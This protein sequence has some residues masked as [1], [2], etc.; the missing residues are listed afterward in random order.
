MWPLTIV[1]FTIL[2][3]R[4]LSVSKNIAI[5]TL[6]DWL[7]A[8]LMAYIIPA[9][10]CNFAGLNFDDHIIHKISRNAL[11]PFTILIVMSSMS[12]KELKSIGWKPLVVFISGS[13]FIALFPVL[14]FIIGKF[15]PYI[16]EWLNAGDQWKGLI[17]V[18]G[19]W[20]GGSISQLVLKEA[21]ECPENVFLSILIFD[22]LMVNIWTIIMFQFIKRSDVINNRLGITAKENL[23][24]INITT[25]N[26][27]GGGWIL[28]V[29]ALITAMNYVLN[30]PFITQIIVLSLTGLMIGNFW[31]GWNKNFALQVA[32]ILIM[33][34]MAILGLKLKFD[35]LSMNVQLILILC[36]WISGHFLFTVFVAWRLKTNMAWVAIGSMA[37][38]GGIATAPAVTATYDKKMMPHAIILAVLSMATGTF[39]GLC[40]IWL[41][42]MWF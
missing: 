14:L 38:V 9:F 34:I 22:N 2:V 21:V 37:N 7:P 30:L 15:V 32:S 20:I 12:L 28:L 33:T 42:G 29:M 16:S 3:I 31:I 40:T 1:V 18:I 41:V 17:T 19:S 13:F 25:S 27:L 8:I 11:I 36:T 5:K 35:N 26:H 10:I 39:W 6:L 4:M 24:K 23:E